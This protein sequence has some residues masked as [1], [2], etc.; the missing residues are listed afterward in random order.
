MMSD[1][2]HARRDPLSGRTLLQACGPQPHVD[3]PLDLTRS[4]PPYFTLLELC[5][6]LGPSPTSCLLSN[7]Q[8]NTYSPNMW[9]VYLEISSMI[10]TCRRSPSFVR[11]LSPLTSGVWMT[12]YK[13]DFGHIN[14]LK[15]LRPTSGFHDIQVSWKSSRTFWTSTASSYVFGDL[16]SCR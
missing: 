10:S 16:Q 11:T 1:Q 15:V 5:L 9:T 8:G 14:R 12:T 3:L 2:P 6:R 7:Q 13:V 4:S